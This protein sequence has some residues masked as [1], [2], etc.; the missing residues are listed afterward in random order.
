MQFTRPTAVPFPE[1]DVEKT[2]PNAYRPFRYGPYHI[3]MGLRN[4]DWNEWIGTWIPTQV[5]DRIANVQR[6]GQSLHEVS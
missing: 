2:K 3:T 1:W 4:M 5:E 6:I